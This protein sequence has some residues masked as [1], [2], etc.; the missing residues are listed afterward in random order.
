MGSAPRRGTRDD[1]ASM[2]EEIQRMTVEF[3]NRKA[4]LDRLR[5]LKARHQ[6]YLAER[7]EAEAIEEEQ[8]KELGGYLNFSGGDEA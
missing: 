8:P 7:R 6:N 4:K 3:E 2:R 5:L 1:K